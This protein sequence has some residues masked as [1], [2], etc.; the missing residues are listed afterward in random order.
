MQL[1]PHSAV[2]RGASVLRTAARC[3]A[4]A[5]KRWMPAAGLLLACAVSLVVLRIHGFHSNGP[6]F[7]SERIGS[8]AAGTGPSDSGIAATKVVADAG[9]AASVDVTFSPLHQPDVDTAALQFDI[10]W[11]AQVA[12]LSVAAGPAAHASG[13]T[14]WTADPGPRMKRVLIAGLN[15]NPIGE[16]A[17]VRLTVQMAASTPPAFYPL[18]IENVVGAGPGGDRV[19]VP[20]RDGGVVVAGSGVPAPEVAAVTNAA[21]YA[22]NSVAP[23]EIVVI[24]GRFLGEDSLTTLQLGSDGRVSTRLA[25]SRVLFDGIPAPLLY[26]TQGQLSAVVPYAVEGRTTT[27]F[28]VEYQGVRSAP[29]ILAVVN[30]SPGVFTVNQSGT[31][32]GAIVN[33]DG[34]LNGPANPAS[35]GSVVSI[36]ATGEGQ[37]IPA[38]ID[39]LLVGRSDLRH[40]RLPVQVFIGGKEAEVLY[41]GSAAELVAGLLQVNARVPQSIEPS[42]TAPVRI[43]IGV[44]S[45]PGTT[46]AVR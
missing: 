30:S 3:R 35:T 43:V 38:G 8:P 34:S 31:G 16:G 24:W 42:D 6:L 10:R 37:T 12:H 40:P 2:S 11:D 23:G 45:Q 32:Q 33:H 26:V 9:G 46:M 4:A 18:V 39:G 14:V 7:A 27:S 29:E 25:G 19:V 1:K 21:S 17:L 36:Y 41:A 15:R 28:Q 44:S 22:P 13:K 5:R 20:S